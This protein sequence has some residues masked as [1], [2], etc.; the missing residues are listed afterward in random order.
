MTRLEELSTLAAVA[1]QEAERQSSILR[2]FETDLRLRGSAMNCREYA[3]TRARIEQQTRRVETATAKARDCQAAL[4]S[5][6]SA[7]AAKLQREVAEHAVDT[8]LG[9]L[10]ETQ[11]AISAK[12]TEAQR[13]AE[14]LPQL[15]HKASQLMA[16]LSAKKEARL[17]LGA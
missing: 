10:R 1:S 13:I 7:E 11:A 8:T 16:E 15:A 14:E 5:V 3:D 6:R 12:R 17:R 9:R 2:E 4:D